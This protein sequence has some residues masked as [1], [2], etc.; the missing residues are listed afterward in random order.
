MFTLPAI[1]PTLMSYESMHGPGRIPARTPDQEEAFR[2]SCKQYHAR[3]RREA[4]LIATTT[5]EANRRRNLTR[6]SLGLPP[7]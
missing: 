2:L 1:L 5:Q 6:A 4:F 7:F 3:K